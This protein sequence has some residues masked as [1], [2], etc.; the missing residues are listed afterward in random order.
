MR[1]PILIQS[2]TART[3]I[4]FPMIRMKPFITSS[5]AVVMF[6][7]IGLSQDLPDLGTENGNV[8]LSRS[9]A[10]IWKTM[11]FEGSEVLPS[12]RTRKADEPAWLVRSDFVLPSNPCVSTNEEFVEAVS[13]SSSMGKIP[14]E[15]VL[16]ALYAAYGDEE[17]CVL[18][19]G[20]E[21][22]T[23]LDAIW[24]EAALLAIWKVNASIGRARV[25]RNGMLLVVVWHKGLSSESW[26]AVN[27]NVAKR[28]G[29]AIS[30]KV[31]DSSGEND[32]VARS[33]GNAGIWKTMIFEGRELLP[34]L[35]TR[36]ADEPVWHMRSGFVLPR[37]PYVSSDAEFVEGI[38]RSSSQ[39]RIPRAGV[40]SALYAAYGGEEKRVLLRG[41]EAA[42]DHD[43]SWREAALRSIWAVNMRFGNI[44]V[45]RKGTLLVVV[46]HQGLSPESWEAVNAS[47]AKRL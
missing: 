12:L 32:N 24:R 34:S 4:R 16:S 46:W 36:Q 11:V 47:V 3:P 44:R 40:Q 23:G 13:R 30:Q 41:L 14:R 29:N 25:H 28:L 19:R 37:N 6:A 1:P 8:P 45:H 33:R 5:L 18:I 7:A 21:A 42:S 39:G 35:K 9:N 26:E 22:A 43:A 2:D 15:G 20:I 38:S 27:A 17:K 31:P 10:G